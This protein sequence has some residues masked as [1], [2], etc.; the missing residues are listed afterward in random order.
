MAIK[1]NNLTA[2][3][4]GFV[5]CYMITKTIINFQLPDNMQSGKFLTF[6]IHRQ[7]MG[8]TRKIIT[9]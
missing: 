6:V 4:Q 5:Y 3:G 9:M 2:V 1:T 8:T 7:I